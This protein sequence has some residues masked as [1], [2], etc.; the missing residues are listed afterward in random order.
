[1][2]VSPDGSASLP[3]P[4]VSHPW[5]LLTRKFVSLGPSGF[6][7]DGGVEKFVVDFKRSV[8]LLRKVEAFSGQS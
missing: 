7:A 8:H 4:T 1:L 2:D 6:A 3:K 5:Q